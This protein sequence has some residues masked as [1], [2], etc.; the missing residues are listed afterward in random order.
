[1]DTTSPRSVRVASIERNTAETKITVRINL[2][3][4]GVYD[5]ASGI[6]FLDH[7][8][9]QLARHSL[10]DI[11]LK[12][13]GDLHIDGHHSTED[14]GIGLGMALRQ[15]LGERIGIQRYGEATIPMDEALTRVALDLSNRPVLGWR[16]AFT[17][18]RLGDLDTELVRE[19]FHA[20]AH[21]AGITLHVD[22]W[23]G[24]N[25]HHIAEGCFKALARALRAAISIDPRR[26][27]AVPSTKGTLG[28]GL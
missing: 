26:A 1:M 8:L 25:N 16:V 5:I 21:A 6:G 2:D 12:V 23:F 17:Q 13:D 27:D 15:A 18:D 10:M 3:G 14:S 24:L 11:T 7:M 9:A 20:F 19:W 4:T 28:K 22:S